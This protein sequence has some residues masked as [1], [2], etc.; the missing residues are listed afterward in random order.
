MTPKQLL[1]NDH[2]LRKNK[3][4][5]AVQQHNGQIVNVYKDLVLRNVWNAIIPKVLHLPW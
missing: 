5:V 1:E 2:E 4:G 3:E